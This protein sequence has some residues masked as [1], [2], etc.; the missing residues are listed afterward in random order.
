MGKLVK[1][2]CKF[3]GTVYTNIRYAV[4]SQCFVCHLLI[5]PSHFSGELCSVIMFLEIFAPSLTTQTQAFFF[6]SCTRGHKEKAVKNGIAQSYIQPC[7]VTFPGDLC[8]PIALREMKHE[9]MHAC[10]FT[11]P[12]SPSPLCW[13]WCFCGSL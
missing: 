6:C 3:W 10:I 13:S 7:A 11:F 1:R 4:V 5:L 12:L 9:G 8:W 2:F